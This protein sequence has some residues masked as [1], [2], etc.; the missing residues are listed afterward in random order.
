MLLHKA[1]SIDLSAH[2]RRLTVEADRLYYAMC[3]LASIT[4]GTPEYERV[5]HAHRRAGDRMLRRRIAAPCD[6]CGKPATRCVETGPKA[7][8]YY[9]AACIAKETSDAAA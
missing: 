9:C 3:V 4:I 2:P 5:K 7:W 8:A 6:V 1:I